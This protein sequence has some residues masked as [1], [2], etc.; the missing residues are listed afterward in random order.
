MLGRTL[1]GCHSGPPQKCTHT[2]CA[3]MHSL[4]YS[5]T[6]THTQTQTQQHTLNLHAHKYTHMRARAHTHTHTH[7]H[8]H[9]HTHKHTHKHI[10]AHTHTDVCGGRDLGPTG[11]CRCR[12]QMQEAGFTHQAQ[13][14]AV[15]QWLHV[16]C[17]SSSRLAAGGGRPSQVWCIQLLHHHGHRCGAR[18]G[19][20]LALSKFISWKFSWKYTSRRTC[21]L[22]MRRTRY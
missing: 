13:P 10:Q 22:I 5:H 17:L 15:P 3:R 7:T 6:H 18:H 16:H 8:I 12:P 4:I 11:G 1:F 9:T 14:A 2:A 19:I 20:R 21:G